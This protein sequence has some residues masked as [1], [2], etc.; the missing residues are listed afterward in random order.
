MIEWLPRFESKCLKNSL[1]VVRKR[2]REEKRREEK[3]EAKPRRLGSIIGKKKL[4]L[5]FSPRLISSA[6][7]HFTTMASTSNAKLDDQVQ[8]QELTA[9][10]VAP[11]NKNKRFRKEKRE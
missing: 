6:N 1:V 7:I 5:C 10:V 8:D 9:D 4:E 2:R 3:G 11:V